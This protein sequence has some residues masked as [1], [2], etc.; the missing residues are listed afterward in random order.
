MAPT[1]TSLARRPDPGAPPGPPR[2]LAIRNGRRARFIATSDVSRIVSAER[3]VVVHTAGGVFAWRESLAQVEALLGP[4]FFVRAHRSTLVN[5]KR[6]V[7]LRSLPGGECAIVLDDGA[8]VLASRG[9]RD[10]LATLEQLLTGHL[11]R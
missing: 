10:L 1:S 2:R 5:A 4:G 3:G 11:S 8:L 6:I 7:E 9:F